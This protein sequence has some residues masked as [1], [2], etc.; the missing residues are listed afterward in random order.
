ME[1]SFALGTQ[2]P[3]P[4]KRFA[5]RLK[6]FVVLARFQKMKAFNAAFSDATGEGACVPALTNKLI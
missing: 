3:S 4:A 5:K 1:K 6:T 2:P